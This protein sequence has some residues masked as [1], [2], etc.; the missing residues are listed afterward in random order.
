M[1]LI[2]IAPVPCMVCGTGNVPTND[3]SP[4]Q[5]VDLERDTF[6]DDPAILCEDCC[7]KI[8]GLMGAPSPEIIF[9]K[10][11]QIRVLTADNHTLRSQLDLTKARARRLGIQFLD[12]KDTEVQEDVA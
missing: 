10:D 4:R 5:F 8:A 3:G 7:L 2:E 1:H 6:W 12:E 9:N 11:K